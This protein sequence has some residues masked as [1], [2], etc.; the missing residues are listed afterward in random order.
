[1]VESAEVSK[2]TPA[3]RGWYGLNDLERRYG[4]F[5]IIRFAMASGTG[6]L[7]NEAILVLGVF[8]FYHT[9]R[10]PS[11]GEASLTILALDAV[12]LGVGD[13]VAFLINER[14]TVK[15]VGEERRKG[16]LHWTERW[17]EYQL[18]SLMG[19]VMIVI[20]QLGL[21]AMISLSPVFG[22]IVGAV[23]SYPVT[24][25]ISMH[26]VWGVRPFHE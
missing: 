1:M 6:F 16:R 4:V 3:S 2:G 10:V 23:V 25:V 9:M 8:T 12:A 19:N 5:R 22:N 18:T 13:T 17:G 7:I 14:V 20:V 26:F 24:Y 15:G 21:L 11:F